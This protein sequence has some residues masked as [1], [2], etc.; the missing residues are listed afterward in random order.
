M[1]TNKELEVKIKECDKRIAALA[2]ANSQLTDEVH[3]LRSNYN[4]LVEDMN[5]RLESVSKQ[6]FL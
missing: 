3:V 2:A 1:A 6:I 5:K 4:K